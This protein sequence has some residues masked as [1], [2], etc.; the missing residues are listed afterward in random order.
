MVAKIYEKDI[1]IIDDETV[2]INRSLNAKRFNEVTGYMPPDWFTLI[3]KMHD[4]R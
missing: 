3:K 1:Q 2:K 4:F